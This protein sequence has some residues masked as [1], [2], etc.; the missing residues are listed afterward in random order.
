LE[1]KNFLVVGESRLE[2][3][4]LVSGIYDAFS[5]ESDD[6]KKKRVK[7]L[8]V[9]R[10]D[11]FDA[12]RELEGAN[13]DPF[14]FILIDIKVAH[15]GKWAASFEIGKKRRLLF[16]SAVEGS[17]KTVLGKIVEIDKAE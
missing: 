13:K 6:P 14:D 16:D 4:N 1:Q 11:V 15:A 17:G 9:Q 10:W 12:L 2:V 8:I 3:S 7:P 5:Q